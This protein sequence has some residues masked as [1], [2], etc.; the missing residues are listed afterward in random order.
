M[1]IE[2]HRYKWIKCLQTLTPNGFNT[3]I[4]HPEKMLSNRIDIY[5]CLLKNVN[6]QI[7]KLNSYG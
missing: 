4:P 6:K 7:A 3:K 1:I 2:K 5:E